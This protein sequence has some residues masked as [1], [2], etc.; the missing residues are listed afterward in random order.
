V[1]PKCW[2]I[3]IVGASWLWGVFLTFR[4]SA[5][6]ADRPDSTS[7]FGLP[8]FLNWSY[9]DSANF[10]PR[11]RPLLRWLW[12]ATSTFAVGVVLAMALCV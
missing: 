2:P 3:V 10:T 7:Y 1:I 12:V 4:V 8:Y 9:L 6:R 11:G 5:F